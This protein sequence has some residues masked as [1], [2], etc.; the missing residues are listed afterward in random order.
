M[1]VKNNLLFDDLDQAVVFRKSPNHSPGIKPLYLIVHYTADTS[2]EGTLAWFSDTAAQASAHLVIDRDGRIVQ[3]VP[4]D[5]RAWHA[6][7][8]RWGELEGMNQYSIGIELVNAG[9][10]RKRSDGEWINWSGKVIPAAEVTLAKAAGEETECGWQE[11][12]AVQIEALLQAALALHAACEFADILGHDQV[13][14]GRKVD[15]G[16]LFPMSSFKS[17]ILGR[18]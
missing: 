17:R 7:K 8:S 2:L 10:L 12:T 3:M 4:F 6:G 18:M 5:R 9:K 15:P 13:A 11:Y 14:P 1:K 16:P